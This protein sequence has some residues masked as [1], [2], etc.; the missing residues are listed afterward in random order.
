MKEL[1][2]VIKEFDGTVYLCERALP[3]K[4]LTEDEL[5]DDIE[6]VGAATFYAHIHDAQV[7]FSF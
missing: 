5:R 4:E 1:L 2:G 3:A 6:T 7:T